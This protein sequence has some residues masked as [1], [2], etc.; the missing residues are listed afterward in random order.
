MAAELE[1]MFYTREKP[2]HG[3]GVRVEKTPASADALRLAGLDWQVVQQPIYTDRMEPIPGYNNTLNLALKGADRSW[4]MIHTGNIK[5][6]EVEGISDFVFINSQGKPYPAGAINRV[7]YDLVKTYNRREEAQAKD[8]HREPER[9]P[10]IS[11]H[12]LRHTACSRWAESGP[13]VLQYIMGHSNIAVTLDIYTHID[14]SQIQ[15]KMDALEKD[16]KIG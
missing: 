9:L 2:W 7:L 11:A 10:H 1:T 13:K 16:E 3:L 15:K 4:S 12:T 6:Q 14:F 8:K 5:Q